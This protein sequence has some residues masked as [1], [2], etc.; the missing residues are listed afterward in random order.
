VKHLVSIVIPCFNAQRW[1]SEAIES[2]L[3]Q[4]YSPLEIIVI[5]DGSTDQS[6]ERV[7]A[8]RG[9]IR[10][11]SQARSGGCHARNRGCALSSGDYIQ[12][13]DADDYLLP[14]KIE[15]QVAVCE[16]TGADVVYGDW[17]HQ[18]HL[19]DGSSSLED[20]AIS[21]KQED[22]L[23]ALLSGWWVASHALL[24][25][26]WVVDKAT[27]WDESLQAA[28]DRDFFISA[29][30]A[31]AT[32]RYA[33]GCGAVYRR[34]GNVTVGT[35][36][37]P[38]WLAAHAR[39]LEKSEARLAAAGRLCDRYR[40]ALARSYFAL[41]RSFY[42]LDRAAHRKYLRKVLALAPGFRPAESPFYNMAQR[43]FGFAIAEKFASLKRKYSRPTPG[44][45]RE[46]AAPSAAIDQT[47]AC[48]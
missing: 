38:R 31:G 39:V 16:T 37:L 36:N 33:P 19:A 21:G 18:H 25:R 9:R 5:D 24:F 48:G 34:Y 35:A 2:C 45:R 3:R 28:Q 43:F 11:E 4:T 6:L 13:L 17:R 20:V 15:Q 29:V 27:G 8:F 47:T 32:I 30:L 40:L 12:F 22:V 23:E 1:I 42:D 26:R 46:K 10:W 44:A 7:Q 14:G 41:A